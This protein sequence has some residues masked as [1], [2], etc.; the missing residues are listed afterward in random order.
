MNEIM[1][2]TVIVTRDEMAY[3]VQRLLANIEE[4]ILEKIFYDEAIAGTL[5]EVFAIQKDGIEFTS[6]FVSIP[7]SIIKKPEES[8]TDLSGRLASKIYNSIVERHKIASV[9]V[10][11][12]NS[13]SIAGEN[14]LGN[15]VTITKENRTVGTEASA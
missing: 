3:M 12:D 1:K 9:L 15:F 13:E 10:A 5:S 2:A 11:T 8:E 14:S 4:K 7:V 6:R